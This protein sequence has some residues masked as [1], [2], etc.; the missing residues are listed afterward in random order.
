MQPLREIFLVHK[1]GNVVTTE[2]QSC[3]VA[4]AA[5]GSVMAF[6]KSSQ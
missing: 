6:G 3:G 4:E 2:N 1:L 5:D